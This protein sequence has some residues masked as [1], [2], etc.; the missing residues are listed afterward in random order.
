MKKQSTGLLVFLLVLAICVTGLAKANDQ[1]LTDDPRVASALKMIE[2]WVE[3]QLAYE[4]IPG[5]SMGI[6][7]DQDLIWSRG[8]GFADVAK[9]R[10][11]TPGTIYSICSISKLFTSISIMQLWEQGKLRLDDPIKKYLP[12][13]QHPG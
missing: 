2:V 3:A 4:D 12:L 11:A 7:Y 9:K 6:V 10:P 1:S 8:F 5:M 13:V